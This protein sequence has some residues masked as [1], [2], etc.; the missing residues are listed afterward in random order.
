MAELFGFMGANDGIIRML[1]AWIV[2]PLIWIVL[3]MFTLLVSF[4]ILWLRRKRRLVFPTIEIVDLGN[5]KFGL[6]NLKAGWF[7]RKKYLFRLIDR[8]EEI[9]ETQYGDEVLDFSTEDYQ[10]V[11]GKRG[12]VCYRDPLNQKILVPINQLEIKNKQLLA[13]IPPASYIDTVIDLVKDSEKETRD[14]TNQIVQWVMFGL[15]VIFALVSIIVIVNYAK[16]S[17]QEANDLVLSAGQTCLSSAKAVCSDIA[18]I[19]VNSGSNAP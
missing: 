17:I 6:N 9:L 19:A 7:G 3:I 4:G 16:S 18:N 11:N 13:E 15:I 14:M 5:K 1:Y 10:E 12:V 2:N 8:G